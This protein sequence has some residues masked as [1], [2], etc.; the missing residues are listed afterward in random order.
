MSHS[1]AWHPDGWAYDRTGPRVLVALPLL[2][3]ASAALVFQSRGGWLILGVLL[4]GAA[5]GIQE[6]TM[7]AV[8]TDLVGSA[9]RATAYGVYAAAAGAVA[10]FG[11]TLTGLL[12][13]ISRTVL[14]SVIVAVQALALL[15]FRYATLMN[16]ASHSDC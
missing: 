6:S 3:A 16:A 13:D 14:I 15:L 5:V 12:Y 4:W 2:A 9:H 11:G 10:A 7:R 8:V 1:T